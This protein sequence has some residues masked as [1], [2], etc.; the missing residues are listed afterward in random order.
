LVDGGGETENFATMEAELNDENKVRDESVHIIVKED[1]TKSNRRNEVTAAT[2]NA[3]AVLAKQER[4]VESF[5]DS[6]SSHGG[7]SFN[8]NCN[9]RNSGVE[10]FSTAAAKE[11]KTLPV[12]EERKDGDNVLSSGA[13]PL[14]VHGKDD[15]GAKK[16]KPETN[17]E[18]AHLGSKD[19]NN[20]NKCNGQPLCTAEETASEF[21]KKRKLEE[22][23]LPDTPKPQQSNV[24]DS[25]KT[26]I[27]DQEPTAKYPQTNYSTTYYPSISLTRLRSLKWAHCRDLMVP[28]LSESQ[29]KNIH[30]RTRAE[31]SEMVEKKVVAGAITPE[32]FWNVVGLDKVRNKS[33]DGGGGA[34]VAK[35]NNYNNSTFPSTT[36]PTHP[37]PTLPSGM[38][39]HPSVRPYLPP[40]NIVSGHAHGPIPPPRY[41]GGPP[42]PHSQIIPPPQPPKPQSMPPPPSVPNM[43]PQF[44][45]P[46][47]QHPAANSQVTARSTFKYTLNAR[48]FWATDHMGY[49]AG[50]L[51]GEPNPPTPQHPHD[52]N[53][54]NISPTNKTKVRPLTTSQT[55]STVQG[56]F[57]SSGIPPVP[58]G[59]DHFLAIKKETDRDKCKINTTIVPKM[60]E[61]L[62]AEK[63][64]H[65]L[66]SKLEMLL[67]LLCCKRSDVFWVNL[68]IVDV[69]SHGRE[70]LDIFRNYF[71]SGKKGN[72]DVRTGGVAL[73]FVGVAGLLH[74]GALVQME[75]R[76][77]VR[78]GP[79]SLFVLEQSGVPLATV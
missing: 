8:N 68:Q 56:I 11:E 51:L 50:I 69:H 75:F 54:I 61:D 25:P 37:A 16:R 4:E 19:V 49:P 58:T 53:T 72:E 48:N 43:H 2:S 59:L 40:R 79:I 47:P 63:Q 36:S 74:E 35:F 31:L 44:S 9:Q 29:K 27:H 52:D 32:R 26:L 64:C 13:D 41:H 17:E 12:R 14:D 78:S 39:P 42:P 1:R 7:V 21:N 18:V 22:L 46:L 76:A 5:V 33:G 34:D 3:A 45:Q 62:S 55:T 10:K 30:K 65:L 77:M 15:A 70:V 66:F 38:P 24:G 57:H 60:E 20:S 23:T 28:F 71:S 73:N 6:S 67:N